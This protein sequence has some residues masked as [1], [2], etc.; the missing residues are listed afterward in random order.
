MMWS[1]TERDLGLGF[2]SGDQGWGH[3]TEWTLEHEMC[4]ETESGTGIEASEQ[5]Q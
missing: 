1:K 5:E 3:E 2:R 4:G